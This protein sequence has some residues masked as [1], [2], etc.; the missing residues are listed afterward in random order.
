[1]NEYTRKIDEILKRG[2]VAERDT[3]QQYLYKR[4]KDEMQRYPL[5]HPTIKDFI[6]KRELG[7]KNMPTINKISK[8]LDRSIDDQIKMMARDCKTTIFKLL[9]PIENVLH[10]FSVKILANLKSPLINDAKEGMK[11]L[12]EC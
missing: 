3:I 9:L 6:I 2:R 1:M 12:I 4:L 5:I 11:N 7:I 10:S 8:G